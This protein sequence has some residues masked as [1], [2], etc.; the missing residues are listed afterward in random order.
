MFCVAFNCIEY[1]TLPGSRLIPLSHST[2][3]IEENGSIHVISI[4]SDGLP[5]NKRS[6]KVTQRTG[7][8]C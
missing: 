5:V 4:R 3:E 7:I 1:V 2:D 8:W 6:A